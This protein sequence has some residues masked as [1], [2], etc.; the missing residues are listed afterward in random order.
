MIYR[1]FD[2]W[3]IKVTEIKEQLIAQNKTTKW[4]PEFVQEKRFHNW[5]VDAKD[6][7][8]SRNRYWGNPIPIWVSDDGEEVVCVGSIKEL[9]ELSGQGPFTDIH[10]EYVDHIEIPSKMG[11]GTLKRIPEVFDCWFESGSMPF[12]QSHYPF[13]VSEED[14]M[15]GFPANFIAE[16]LD[17]TRGWFYTLMVIST[18]IKGVAPFQNLIC[19]GIVLAEDGTKMSK[20]KKNYPDPVFMAEQ[21][22]ADATRLY[23]CNSPVVR[24]EPLKFSAEG[25]KTI[26]RDIFLPWFNAYRFLIQNITRW[27]KRTGGNFV[28]DPELKFAV[29]NDANSNFMDRYIIA[30]NQHLIRDVRKEMDD[31]KLYSVVKHILE[32]LENLTN[33]YVRLNR[34]RMKGEENTAE[35]QRIAL[36]TLFDVLLNATQLMAPITPFLCEHIYQNM[37]NGLPEDS[38]LKK[39]SIH[40]TDIPSHSEA[41]IDLATEETVTHMQHAIETGRL[42]RDRINIPMKYPLSKVFIVDANE[43]TLA[44]YKTLEKYIKEEL[45]VLEVVLTKDEDS[46]VVYKAS[47]DNRAMGQAFGKKFDKNMRQQVENLSSDQIRTFLSTGSVQV[48]ELTITQ[49]MLKVTK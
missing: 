38:P 5:L 36:N 32:F 42:I 6:W 27:E 35:D 47:P 7:C 43:Q 8:F 19:N 12:A 49:D 45:N 28:F 24:A 15:K 1:G 21:Y 22:G 26:V 41:L 16:G 2:C 33:W 4:I 48:G 25:V 17:Q 9:E 40:F 18:A 23:L 3:F 39:E 46:Y 11:K 34:P 44:G 20:S 14:F 31:Y 29:K 37:R 30:A 10:R 13:S